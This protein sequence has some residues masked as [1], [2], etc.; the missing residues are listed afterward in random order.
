MCEHCLF[1]C[2]IKLIQTWE[3]ILNKDVWLIE[4]V[5]VTDWTDLYYYNN[6]EGHIYIQMVLIYTENNPHCGFKLFKYPCSSVAH[7]AS[8]GKVMGSIQ[9]IHERQNCISSKQY[10]SLWIKVSECLLTLSAN[11]LP[12][13]QRLFT[14]HVH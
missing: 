3:L 2:R 5:N 12:W 6:E 14:L 10:T 4:D 11:S 1:F 8:N 7:D 9:G 13:R